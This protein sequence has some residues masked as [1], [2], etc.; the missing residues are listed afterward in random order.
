MQRGNETQRW[1][2][3]SG[4]RGDRRNSPDQRHESATNRAALGSERH[5]R[6]KGDERGTE[7]G[8]KEGKMREQRGERKRE[9]EKVGGER[10]GEKEEDPEMAR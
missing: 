1:R 7:E 8:R 4:D 10:E 9:R 6:E 5:A 3:R 2:D